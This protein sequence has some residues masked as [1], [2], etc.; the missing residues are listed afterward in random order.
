MAKAQGF[1]LVELLAAM[2]A[3]ALLLLALGNVTGGLAGRLTHIERFDT[4]ERQAADNAAFVAII[5]RAI[6]SNQ[7]DQFAASAARLLFPITPPQAMAGA[8]QLLAELTVEGTAPDQHLM[9]RLVRVS[10]AE[11][12]AASETVLFEHMASITINSDLVHHNS[13]DTRLGGVRLDMVT[14]S[15]AV[16]QRSASPRITARPGC[17]FDP[18]SLECRPE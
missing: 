18:I 5:H 2:V 7:P 16:W 10:D 12:L 17:R 14:R 11:P 8:E 4:I 15:G 6:P 1:T 3:A 13:S 9:L